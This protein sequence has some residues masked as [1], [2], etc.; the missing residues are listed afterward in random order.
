MK[1]K[2]LALTIVL[3][4]VVVSF[5]AV[6]AQIEKITEHSSSYQPSEKIISSML[7]P[8]ERYDTYGW[9]FDYGNDLDPYGD[10]S[11]RLTGNIVLNPKAVY[12][13]N[14]RCSDL[15]MQEGSLNVG[16]YFCDIGFLNVGD[17]PTVSIWNYNIN[18]WQ[19]LAQ[20]IG[21]NDELTWWWSGPISNSNNYVST[22]EYVQLKFQCGGNDDT[23]IDT[24]SVK[25]VDNEK[26]D[27]SQTNCNG[28]APLSDGLYQA[29]TPTFEKLTR[30]KL[31]LRS[32]NKMDTGGSFY[33][34]ICTD[35]DPRTPVTGMQVVV[36]YGIQS[37]LGPDKW[38]ECD[39]GDNYIALIPG[40]TYYLEI[41]QMGSTCSWCY[42]GNSGNPV[43][44]FKTYGSE[45]CSL[46]P[47]MKVS[48]TSLAFG[49]VKKGDTVRPTCF[50]IENIGDK[51]S[52]FQW[53]IPNNYPSWIIVD[54]NDGIIYN[55]RGGN[56][57]DAIGVSVDTSNLEGSRE[58]TP[59]SGEI[60]VKDITT[61]KTVKVTVSVSVIKNRA[62]DFQYNL[63]QKVL[64]KFTELIKI[65]EL[66]IFG[67]L[68]G[69][70]T[71]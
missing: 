39:L 17:G 21:S 13:T 42:S 36:N 58:G 33:F 53:E 11:V 57:V 18:N 62:R 45:S 29:F 4:M 69:L 19:E 22:D 67:N 60:T 27:Q 15:G 68:K 20:N 14:I 34:Y 12:L 10:H 32:N 7:N 40:L 59:Y 37:V 9:N 65:M 35:M 46:V 66:C 28:A 16:V 54:K 56:Q 6:G 49:N 1:G 8:E 52:V 61:G 47:N 41:G 64:D 51:G 30:I 24:V 48:P 5:G 31:L 63:L 50:Y 70:I 25:F 71:N 55:P 3:L 26:T 44:C 38:I 23:I 43:Y 2:I